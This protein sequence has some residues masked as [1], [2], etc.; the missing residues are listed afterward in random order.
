MEHAVAHGF[1]CIDVG[2]VADRGSTWPQPPPS[3]R[4]YGSAR[5]YMDRRVLAAGPLL[6]VGS[7]AL[8]SFSHASGAS[9][10]HCPG[11]PGSANHSFAYTGRVT[12]Q[13]S[14]SK[15]LKQFLRTGSDGLH[16]P[17]GTWTHPSKNLFVYSGIHGNIEVTTFRLP[18]GSYVVTQAN[19]TCSTF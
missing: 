17:L 11:T 13:S 3:E 7:A 1:G 12:G 10:F 5:R 2:L 15:A 19:Q 6:V 9:G 16:L 18:K 8:L 4:L 14:P